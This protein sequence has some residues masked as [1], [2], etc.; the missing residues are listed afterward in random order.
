MSVSWLFESVISMILFRAVPVS[1]DWEVRNSKKHKQ[2]C[3]LGAKCSQFLDGR[4]I[5]VEVAK[6]RS[7][8]RQSPK[9]NPRRF[10]RAAILVKD[11]NCYCSAILP[12][13]ILMHHV[14]WLSLSLCFCPS[15]SNL[16]FTYNYSVSSFYSR[17]LRRIILMLLAFGFP[18]VYVLPA[19]IAAIRTISKLIS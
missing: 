2:D 6:P 9:Q 3:K 5:F 19:L 14:K 11:A 17:L 10:W 13:T 8:L 12:I 16:S 7:E 1:F 18:L 15:M 4:V